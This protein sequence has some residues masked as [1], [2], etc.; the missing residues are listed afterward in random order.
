[1]K[2]NKFQNKYHEEAKKIL[3]ETNLHRIKFYRK[4]LFNGCRQY[5]YEYKL[6]RKTNLYLPLFFDGQDK[7]TS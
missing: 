7:L 2:L 5:L 1:M 4:L 6:D 3:E